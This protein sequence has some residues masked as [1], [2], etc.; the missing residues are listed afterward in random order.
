MAT[1]SRISA[2]IAVCLAGALLT[3]PA[4]MAQPPAGGADDDGVQAMQPRDVDLYVEAVPGDLALGQAWT[5]PVP[6]QPYTTAMGRPVKIRG[7]ASLALAGKTLSVTVTSRQKKEPPG[8]PDQGCPAGTQEMDTGAQTMSDQTRPQP[9]TV[10]QVDIR[11]SGTF[12]TVYT[13]SVTGT[14]QILANAGTV[15]AKSEF[16]VVDPVTLCEPLSPKEIEQEARQLSETTYQTVDLVD[17]HIQALPDSPAK[18]EFKNKLGELRKAMQSAQ[19]RGQAPGWVKSIEP[20]NRLRSLSPRI[21]QA[22]EP[23][24]RQL[25][26]WRNKARQSNQQSKQ[27]LAKL[28]HGN[29]VCDQ[30]DIVINA[31]K[32]VDFSLGLVT[33]PGQLIE[34]WLKENVP[35]KL[36]GQISGADKVPAV[37]QTI[38]SL[39]KFSLTYASGWSGLA[40]PK[41][42]NDLVG[43]AANRY[44][45]RYCQTFT[46]PVAAEMK[47]V[48]SKIGAPWWWFRIKTS[49]LLILRYPKGATGAAIPLSGE[50]IGNAS[51]FK[52]KDDAIRVLFPKFAKGTVFHQ[53]RIEPL[54]GNMLN[55]G[56][57]SG[58]DPGSIMMDKGGTMVRSLAPAFFRIP[59]RG[60]LR[61]DRLRIELQPAVVDFKDKYTTVRQVTLSPLSMFP[62]VTDYELPYPG[63]HTIF[64]RAFNDGPAEFVVTRIGAKKDVMQIKQHFTRQRDTNRTHGEFSVDVTACNPSCP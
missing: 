1:T 4:A 26:E 51:L 3:L 9:P 35:T 37:Q 23:L 15:D 7:V 40:L 12:E 63:A 64:Q 38:E 50:L 13:P 25:S 28:Q 8:P 46:G 53:T 29:V 11:N 39:W 41:V 33:T 62:N 2:R 31:L 21:R 18:D 24:R 5:A 19:P 22:G 10:L 16:D 49:G 42:A 36:I 34:G 54:A 55:D 57:Y 47:G 30:L 56:D 45:D 17:Q 48:V 27:M 6:G 32:F 52:S 44:F 58:Y 20:F 59:V 43:Y 60:E 61:G 14:H